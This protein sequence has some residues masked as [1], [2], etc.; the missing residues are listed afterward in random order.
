MVNQVYNED[1]L[2]GMQRIP[3]KSID[4]ILCDLPYGTTNCKWDVVIPFAPLWEQYERI[5]KDEGAIV[6][7]G[8]QPFTSLLIMSNPDLFKYELIWD[9][10]IATGFL[11]ANKQ[12]LRKHKNVLIFYKKQ[13]CYNPQKTISKKKTGSIRTRVLGNTDV[14]RDFGPNDWID[15]GTRYPV[16]VIHIQHDD[17]R[18]NTSVSKPL[19]HSTQKPVGLFEYFIK[20][21]TKEGGTVL[22]NCMGSGTTAIA[23]IN[24]N[25]N[26]IGFENNEKHFCNIQ[27]RIRRHTVQLKLTA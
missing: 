25:R 16:S 12:P 10:S 5:I 22:D 3:D 8:S 11:N 14:Y 17:E 15:D 27:E 21:Y 2:I 26:Y 19:K 20:T 18:Y 7:T 6:L 1:C 9:K 23:C 24:T 13:P 4:M